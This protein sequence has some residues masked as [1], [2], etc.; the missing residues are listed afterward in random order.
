MLSTLVLVSVY[1]LFTVSAQAF[2]GVG[3]TGLGLANPDNA[4]DVVA[5]LGTAVFGDSVLGQ[6]AV[7]ALIVMVLTSAAASTQ[8]TILP[9]A[10]TS[11]AMAYHGALPAVF[12]KAH[13]RFA[14]PHV[15]TW[16]MGAASAVL[17]IVLDLAGSGGLVLDAVAA[18]GVAI[19]FY[20]G[21]TALASA[22]L[23]SGSRLR[24]EHARSQP[25]TG[26]RAPDWRRVVFPLL[27]GV[28]LLGAALWTAVASFSADFGEN[29]WTIP[30]TG[31]EVG[32]VFLLGV[33]GMLLGVPF[34]LWCRAVEPLFAA[35]GFAR[36]LPASPDQVDAV[37]RD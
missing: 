27:G 17:Y 29:S 15:S 33:G 30:G 26:M 8:T 20:Y 10:R 3:D 21:M 11:F 34:M 36:Q 6:I 28:L 23:Y 22:R 7:S 25:H 19:G 24:P 1:V 14:T 32:A 18:C 16:A 5:A 4:D 2:A 35:G 31:L 37:V 13:P 12:G 9:T